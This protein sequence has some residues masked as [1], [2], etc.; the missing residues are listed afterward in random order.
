MSRNNTIGLIV[1]GFVFLIVYMSTFIVDQRERAVLKQLGQLVEK[2]YEPGL[3]FK[4]PFYQ[5]VIK[6]DS[7]ILTLD[8]RP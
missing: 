1:I 6:F 7:R 3:H 2:E 5:N 4:V 8:S